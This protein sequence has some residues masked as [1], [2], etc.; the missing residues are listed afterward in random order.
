M[1]K[2]KI[3]NIIEWEYDYL[4]KL[5]ITNKNIEP[6]TKKAIYEEFTDSLDRVIEVIKDEIKD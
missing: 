1:N 4:V 3:V 6:K 2:K 5:I